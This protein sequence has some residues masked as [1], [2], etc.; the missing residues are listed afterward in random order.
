MIDRD[1]RNKTYDAIG[2]SNLYI[3][4][5]I[6][7]IDAHEEV[8]KLAPL[9]VVFSELEKRI[10]IIDEFFTEYEASQNNLKT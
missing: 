10:A 3:Q 9:V 8:D 1:K 2:T 6:S 5:G 4:L 7:Y